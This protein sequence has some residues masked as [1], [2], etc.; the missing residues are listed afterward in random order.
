MEYPV[1]QTTQ[2]WVDQVRRATVAGTSQAG[3]GAFP[4]W[5]GRTCQPAAGTHLRHTSPA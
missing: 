5:A 4:E 2:F 1:S 3:A